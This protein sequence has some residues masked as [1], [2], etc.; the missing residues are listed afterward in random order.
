MSSM[1]WRSSPS[2]VCAL[3][4]MET[5]SPFAGR[6]DS[7][8][9]SSPGRL[10]TAGWSPKPLTFCRTFWSMGATKVSTSSVSSADARG[11]EGGATRD[12]WGARC[13]ARRRGGQATIGGRASFTHGALR[14]KLRAGS[15]DADATIPT[16]AGVAL[17]EEDA[18]V[19]LAPSVRVAPP[20]VRLA[21]ARAR[22]WAERWPKAGNWRE[23]QI[24]VVV[25]LVQDIRPT[26]L[27]P[28]CT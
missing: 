17:E 19:V 16:H 22:A 10:E 20:V 24:F 11:R 7:P 14:V 5:R 25:P 27:F 8:V 3:K 26:G 23:I 13:D 12:V 1:V 9:S 4:T 6:E 2:S 15:G 21:L 28:N 18:R